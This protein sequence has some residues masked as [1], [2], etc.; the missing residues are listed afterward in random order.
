MPH[1]VLL[2]FVCVL[3]GFGLMK[4][5]LTGTF[6]AGLGTIIHVIGLLAV[7]VFSIVLL[8]MG[9]IALLKKNF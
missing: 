6:L 7:I 8:Y 1:P 4:L 5:V 2:Y 3:V 9:V